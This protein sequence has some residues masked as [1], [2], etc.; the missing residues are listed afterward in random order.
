M[1]TVGKT[2]K[3]NLVA[4]EKMVVVIFL[5][6]SI[7]V[8]S[9]NC[10]KWVLGYL[11]T[12]HQG[13]DGNVGDL[14][15]FDFSRVTHI[16]HHGPYLYGDG[17]LD[18]N[19]N[20]CTPEKMA[21]AVQASHN[22]NKPILISIVSWVSYM[23]SLETPEKRTV[24][25]NELLY[26]LDTY[27]YDGVDVDLEPVMSPY[28]GGMQTDNPVYFAFINQLYDSLSIR[29][30]AMLG[31]QP[32]LT[33]ATNSYGAP[34]LHQLENKLDMMNIMTYD[35]TNSWVDY[36]NFTWHD[37]P[38]YDYS[39]NGWPSVHNMVQEMRQEGI[40]ASK[41]GIGVSFDAFRWQGG[42]GTPTGGVTA[43]AQTYSTTPSWTRF[44]YEYM[45]DN[46]YNNA[47]YRW[48]NVA[49]M[50]YLSI[51]NPNDADDQFWSYNDEVSCEAKAEY[52][53]QEDLGGVII[54]ELY[55]G[56]RNSLPTENHIPQLTATYNALCPSSSKVDNM[57]E[58]NISIFP[59]PLKNNQ[60]LTII[61][62]ENE[63]EKIEFLNN[64]GVSL[65][66]KNCIGL[67]KQINIE[68]ADNFLKN[69]GIYL[70]KIIKNDSIK[71]LKLIKK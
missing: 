18:Y 4:L 28:V 10:D 40:A 21:G 41:I 66:I 61:N 67:G 6:L 14:N 71:Y 38:V 42:S 15:D 55:L 5:L 53:L 64:Q 13:G 36:N 7:T 16:G 24:A 45:M 39:G 68:N 48:D 58:H 20:G 1:K 26:L 30:N 65:Y 34:V 32:L 69:E 19:A 33:C 31:R 22:H 46:V 54:W 27:G 70:V 62:D 47:Y 50:S 59:N 37:A 35:M 56:L 49:K 63:I 23:Q 12:Y 51:D 44:S 57:E 43:P 8:N 2:N 17:S 9:Q 3:T 29:Y 60:T 52:V 11:P 25:I